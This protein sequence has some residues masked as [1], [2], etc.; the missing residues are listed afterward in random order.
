MEGRASYQAQQVLTLVNYCHA[1]MLLREVCGSGNRPQNR[2][3]SIS[4]KV[5]LSPVRS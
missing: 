5:I 1:A 4:S 2:M 3:R